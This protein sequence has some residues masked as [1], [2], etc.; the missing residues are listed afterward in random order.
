MEDGSCPYE[1]LGVPTTAT[2]AEIRKAYKKLALKYHPDKNPDDPETAEKMFRRAV[3]A[4]EM[5]LDATAKAAYDK[6]LKARQAARVRSEKMDAEHRKAREDLE[7]REQAHKRSKTAAETLQRDLEAQIRRLRAEGA[8]KLQEEEDRFREM[9]RTV[10]RGDQDATVVKSD[11]SEDFEAKVLA[12]MRAHGHAR[13]EHMQQQ[14]QQ[15][16]A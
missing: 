2:E 5:L 1:V 13:R 11:F 4:S 6:V 14:Q 7:A 15:Q 10:N 16:A 8:R 12:R 9:L 3:M